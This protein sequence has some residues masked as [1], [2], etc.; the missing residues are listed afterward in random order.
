MMK[1]DETKSYTL[2]QP[3]KPVALVMDS[4]H[5]GKMY[6]SDFRYECSIEDLRFAEDTHVDTLWSTAPSLGIPLLAARAARTYIDCNRSLDD[7]DPGTVEGG[8]PA[9]IQT[10]QRLALGSGLI[11][12]KIGSDVTIFSGKLTQQAVSSRIADY[13]LPYHAALS[14]TL[15]QAYQRHK[16]VWHLNLH[17]MRSTAYEYLGISSVQP[18]ADF[19]LGDRNGTSCDPE[20]TRMVEGMLRDLGYSVSINDPYKGAE[21]LSRYG[22]PEHGRH[23]LQ[24]E[25][26]RDVYMDEKT[27]KPHEGFETLR[28]NLALVTKSLVDYV[29]RE[30]S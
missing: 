6:P 30:T 15:E 26:R 20:F 9:A 28:A 17:S 2:I 12:S 24:I 25:I 3:D 1:Q 11:W 7:I 5:S 21:I 18:L 23:S 8:W 19:V 16:S 4:P 10:S 14:H 27:R 22:R 13:Y 29:V